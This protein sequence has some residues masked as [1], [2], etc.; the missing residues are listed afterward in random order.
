MNVPEPAMYRLYSVAL[1][2][3]LPLAVGR[4]L[5]RSLRSPGYRARWDERLA[6]GEAL[7]RVVGASGGIWIHAVSVGEVQAVVPLVKRLLKRYPVLSI[8]VTTTTPT[9]SRR[10][11]ELFGESVS[12]VY[13]PYDVPGAV[14]RFLD[15]LAP[16]LAIFVETEI[17]PNILRLCERRGIPT[18][19][20]NGRL[21]ARSAAGYGRLGGFA[22]EVVR[23]LTGIAAQ[24]EADAERFVALGADP[25]RVRV[26]NS[27][28]FDVKLPA[29]V[30]EQGEVVQRLWGENRPAWIAASTHEG[31]DELLLAVHVRVLR[32]YPN[33]LL[34]L[35]PRHPERFDRVA[36]LCERRGLALVRRSEHRPCGPDTRVFLGDS[37]GELPI[38][39]AGADLA[40]VGGSLVPHGGHN[41][42]EPAALGVPVLFGPHMFNFAAIS[43][44]LVQSQA[45]LQVD[46]PEDLAEKLVAWLG[47]A[48]TRSRYGE[49][50]RQ[51]VERNR[52]ALDKLMGWVE[53]LL[54]PGEDVS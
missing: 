11:T 16:R 12:H 19:L 26:T 6:K 23:G 52:G 20:A 40:F 10:V 46:G 54:A 31:E 18:L 30:L 8:C 41:V 34:V 29:S 27:I 24:S 2:L 39:L 53:Q 45:A 50:G 37:M 9:G 15:R 7:E 25:S 32:D 28:K 17:W 22:C 36:Q 47:D 44:L 5:W 51:V 42:L 21:S 38:F 33:A 3:L 48:E 43:A 1:Y 35:V 4:L 14:A 13:A 49:N